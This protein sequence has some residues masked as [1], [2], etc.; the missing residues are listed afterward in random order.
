MNPRPLKIAAA[1]APSRSRPSNYPAEFA[2]RMEQ[3]VE[4]LERDA[5]FAGDVSHELRSPL[6]TLAT[7]VE[8]MRH[9]R[10]QMSQE[11]RA[12][13]DLLATDVGTFQQFVEDLL[14]IAK[15]DAGASSMHFEEVHL[16]ELVHQCV[17]SATSRRQLREVPILE[18][19][20]VE[21]VRV[22]VDRRRFER[23]VANLLDN[24]DRYG[25]GATAVRIMRDGTYVVVNIDDA[26][27]GV[28]E[29]DRHRLFDRFYRGSFANDR[30]ASRGTGLG[31]AIV[32]D[33]VQHFGGH[34]SITVSPDGGARFTIELPILREERS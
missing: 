5:R 12:A 29:H 10:E 28:E 22:L 18:D 16:S 21:T 32:T 9:S 24:A 2:A 31:L 33:H 25:G 8:V 26:G 34:V 14:E 17:R 4:Q 1:D 3:L 30:G 15:S 6:T 11:G 20:G 23:V 7:T 27:P 13:F 19:D